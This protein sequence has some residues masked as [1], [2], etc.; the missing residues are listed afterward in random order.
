VGEFLPGR[1]AIFRQLEGA[2]GRRRGA[3]FR[4]LDVT[5]NGRPIRGSRSPIFQRV[6]A[7][8]E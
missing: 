8:G 5:E 6:N 4:Q 1:R 7:R 3:I 2:A